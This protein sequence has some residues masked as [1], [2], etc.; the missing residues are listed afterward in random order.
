MNK[1]VS[2]EPFY[3]EHLLKIMRELRAANRLVHPHKDAALY[4]LRAEAYN[5]CVAQLVDLGIPIHGITP[6]PRPPH[7]VDQRI[8]RGSFTLTWHSAPEGR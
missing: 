3:I 2:V 5:A 7:E 1:P 8:A 6:Y 4:A